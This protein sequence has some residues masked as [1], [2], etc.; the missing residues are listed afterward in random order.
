[1]HQSKLGIIRSPCDP[2]ST[3]R[4]SSKTVS[5]KLVTCHR[6]V[7]DKALHGK[8]RAGWKI[9]MLKICTWNVGGLN[10]TGKLH[11]LE[12]T[13]KNVN[14]AGVS[15][16]HWRERADISKQQTEIWRFVQVIT[17]SQSTELL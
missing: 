15:E 14:I 7:D 8:Y 17:K 16:T 2:P 3:R 1:M 11:V 4:C 9:H 12:Q 6:D 13:L 10:K 5:V